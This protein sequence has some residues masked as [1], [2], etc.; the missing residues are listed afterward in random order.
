MEKE[1]EVLDTQNNQ[2]DVV[3]VVKKVEVPEEEW[4]DL[5]HKAEV[6]SQNFERAKKAEAKLSELVLQTEGNS[7]DAFSDEGKA[8]QGEIRALTSELSNVKGELSK[9]DVLIAHPIL[10]EKWTEFETF[11]AD[12]DNKGM[13][14][15]TAAKAFLVEN[16]LLDTP[17][18]GLERTTGGERIAPSTK[19]TPEE[20]KTLRETNFKKYT[21]YLEKG[22]I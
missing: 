17:R 9:K 6:S 15:K 10:K 1:T 8:L 22:I 5:K 2:A 21:E 16:G 12:P 4:N 3:P 11:R 18:K 14:L 20:I 19:M 13:N 7:F